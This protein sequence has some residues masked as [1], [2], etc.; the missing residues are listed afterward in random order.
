M[1]DGGG[2]EAAGWVAQLTLSVAAIPSPI[3][4]FIQFFTFMAIPLSH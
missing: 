4:L 2:G 1:V 3:R